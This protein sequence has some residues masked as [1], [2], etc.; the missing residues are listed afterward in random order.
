MLSFEIHYVCESSR[1]ESSYYSILVIAFI[2]YHY[3]HHLRTLAPKAITPAYSA[4]G[5]HAV[6]ALRSLICV[7]FVISSCCCHVVDSKVCGSRNLTNTNNHLR[8]LLTLK[9]SPIVVLRPRSESI[10]LKF[11]TCLVSPSLVHLVIN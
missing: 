7:I 2:H 11:Q 1:V 6:A 5:L 3:H 8:Q 10:F 9:M 4:T